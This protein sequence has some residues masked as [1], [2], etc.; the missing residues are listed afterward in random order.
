MAVRLSAL[1]AGHP[2][3]SRKILVIIS[4]GGRVDTRAIVWLEGLGQFK[5]PMASSRME[6]ATFWLVAECLNQLH[7]N[8]H[9]WYIKSFHWVLSMFSICCLTAMWLSPSLVHYLT[10]CIM[11]SPRRTRNMYSE[12]KQFHYVCRSRETDALLLMLKWKCSHEIWT[13]LTGI[14]EKGFT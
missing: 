13:S 4:V 6:P 7:W 3:P 5:N 1:C 10:N 9:F 8:Q 11:Q 2:L 14:P 12:D